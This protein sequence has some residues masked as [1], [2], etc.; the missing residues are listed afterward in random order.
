MDN[1]AIGSIIA[2]ILDYKTFLKLNQNNNDNDFNPSKTNWAPCDGRVVTKSK[3]ASAIDPSGGEVKAPDLRGV[4]LRCI[5]SIYEDGKAG[6]INNEQL[7][8][9]PVNIGNFQNDG[10]KNHAHIFS[11][12]REG[13]GPNQAERGG[14]VGFR[15]REESQ[16]STAGGC[17]ETR[18]KNISVFY[19][20]KIN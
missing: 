14:D 4:F 12:E 7:N 10:L 17:K 15:R 13:S 1:T 5:N 3:Y 9:D 8:P 16:T 6:S 18:T 19:Y 20:L 2:S 11:Y